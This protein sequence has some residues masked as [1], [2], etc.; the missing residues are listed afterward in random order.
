MSARLF[1]V[2]T[3]AGAVAHASA[4]DYTQWRGENRDGSTSA[5][6][7]PKSWPETLTRRWRVE[8][9]DGYATP[10]VVG[11]TVYV[12]TRRDGNEIMQAFDAETGVERWR[13][14]Y[15]APYSPSQAAAAHGA[16]PKATPLYYQGRLFT[17]GISGIVAAF[18]AETGRALWRTD[19]PTEHP[20]FSAASSPVADGGLILTHPGNYG[21]VTA[22]DAST[23][24]VKWTTGAGGFFQ[25]PIIVALGGT[26]QVVTVTQKSVIGVS[27]PSGELLWEYP[28]PGDAGGTMPVLHGDNVIVSAL[29]A[30][31][32]C[33]RPTRRDGKWTVERV[34]ETKDVSMYIS[35]PVV[36]GDTLLGLSRRNRG[37]FFALDARTGAVLWLGPPRAAENAAFAT[38]GDLLFILKD[39]GEL[40]VARASRTGLE[41]L[42]RYT[43]ADSATWAQP[44]ITGRR[45]YIKDV[46]SLS[47]WSFE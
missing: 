39:D 24:A 12:F 20:F 30:G 27:L 3:V 5:F 33:L 46:S 17:V 2:V 26:R 14:S 31:V 23:G 43:V 15:P 21:P 40:M 7:E 38:A 47:L 4:Q 22:F 32:T 6:V 1:A 13:S 45:L 9:G 18:D 37:Q 16:G 25:S 11:R 36:V 44:A 28:F 19:A 34:W 10:L 8:V 41:P 42:K 35:D 29:D